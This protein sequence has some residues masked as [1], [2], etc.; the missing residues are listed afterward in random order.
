MLYAFNVQ[1]IWKKKPVMYINYT[2]FKIITFNENENLLLSRLKIL[3]SSAIAR[4][5]NPGLLSD[6]YIVNVFPEPV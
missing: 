5:V 1:I 2:I 4:G 6:P 3:K